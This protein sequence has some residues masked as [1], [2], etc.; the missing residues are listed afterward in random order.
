M[1]NQNNRQPARGG[2]WEIDDVI[3]EQPLTFPSPPHALQWSHVK[4]LIQP[5]P[6]APPGLVNSEHH[7]PNRWLCLVHYAPPQY[8]IQEPCSP[9]D[10]LHGQKGGE[11]VPVH[12][13]A[14]PRGA[15]A[16][17]SLLAVHQEVGIILL[18]LI[19]MTIMTMMMTLA[20]MMM[21]TIVT[22]MTTLMVMMMTSQNCNQWFF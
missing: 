20:A 5:R 19:M 22:M 12:G 8:K 15:W 17:C 6:S 1:I 14:R 13:L 2:G 11:T 7:T 10:G 18:K 9:S 21:T 4:L 16:F 3:Y